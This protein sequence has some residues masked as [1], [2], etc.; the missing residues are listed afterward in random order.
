MGFEGAKFDPTY[1]M[2]FHCLIP[3]SPVFLLEDL[4]VIP[5]PYAV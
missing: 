3:L 2:L 1:R 5:I 4:F